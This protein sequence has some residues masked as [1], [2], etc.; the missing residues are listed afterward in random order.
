MSL[1]IE[2]SCRV[3]KSRP[4][5]VS[6]NSNNKQIQP[7]EKYKQNFDVSKVLSDSQNNKLY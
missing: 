3:V 5:C 6:L 1:K 7:P 2:N 4:V